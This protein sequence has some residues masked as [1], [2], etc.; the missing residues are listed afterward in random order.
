MDTV[1]NI[2]EEEIS[3]KEVK[4][5]L[6]ILVSIFLDVN[7]KGKHEPEDQRFTIIVND[8]T[9]KNNLYRIQNRTR[10]INYGRSQY[11]K[12]LITQDYRKN[13]YTKDLAIPDKRK[14]LIIL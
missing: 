5:Y 4:L 6:F 12:K 8:I 7:I 13:K 10:N 1:E 9:I 3:D 14:E 2:I 11:T